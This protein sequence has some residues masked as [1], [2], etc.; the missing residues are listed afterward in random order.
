M[1]Q[2]QQQQ[3]QN[4]NILKHQISSSSSYCWSH[5]TTIIA[6]DLVGT[7]TAVH[8]FQISIQLSSNDNSLKSST[9]SYS[10]TTAD[11]DGSIFEQQQQQQYYY[12]YNDDNFRSYLDNNDDVVVGHNNDNKNNNN[13]INIKRH[14]I[15]S[16]GTT[17]GHLIL[18]EMFLPKMSTNEDYNDNNDDQINLSTNIINNNRTKMTSSATTMANTFRIIYH[19]REMTT[20]PIDMIRFDEFGNRIFIADTS[21]KL[22]VLCNVHEL[23]INA[24]TTTTT[25]T[26]KT[27]TNAIDNIGP[28]LCPTI[29]INLNGIG[30]NQ[31]DVCEKYFTFS[32]NENRIYFFNFNDAN[33]FQVGKS[34]VHM[35][36]P[37]GV[38]IIP[39]INNDY[40]NNGDD[41]DQ[42]S[43]ISDDNYDNDLIY[44]TFI[45]R[46]KCRLWEVNE[47]GQIEFTHQF[48]ELVNRSTTV[49]MDNNNTNN[50]PIFN[51]NTGI[52]ENH[53]NFQHS[54]KQLNYEKVHS[55]G[56][57]YLMYHPVSCDY[58]LVTYATTQQRRRLTTTIESKNV[59][60][61]RIYVIDIHDQSLVAISE[62][63]DGR[64]DV[65]KCLQ[66]EIYVSYYLTND[67]TTNRLRMFVM[68]LNFK[69]SN[70][71][72]SKSSSLLSMD[73]VV[74]QHPTIVS[75]GFSSDPN[76][77]EQETPVEEEEIEIIPVISKNKSLLNL[78]NQLLQK[79]SRL[80]LTSTLHN[81]EEEFE[82]YNCSQCDLPV[83]N[84]FRCI[85]QNQSDQL[86]FETIYSNIETD[87]YEEL[88]SIAKSRRNWPM[89]LRL[90]LA[91]PRLDDRFLFMAILTDDPCLI[92]E[93]SRIK[94]I[95]ESIQWENCLKNLHCQ[96]ISS[97]TESYDRM[98][99]QSDHRCRLCLLRMENNRKK[100]I[101]F[102]EKTFLLSS[103][104]HCHSDIIINELI[105]KTL[106]ILD[107]NPENSYAFSIDFYIRI[108]CYKIMDAAIVDH[109]RLL[110][111]KF[112]QRI[113]RNDNHQ[114][115]GNIEK[116]F[117]DWND[118]QSTY[119]EM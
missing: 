35:N 53:E 76:S 57:L 43:T 51:D 84:F 101:E 8:F 2:H 40:N 59:D 102:F 39:V 56:R 34:T 67:L 113:K 89:Y 103:L 86:L 79:T 32:S 116:N 46:P 10:S 13:I 48:M 11:N 95:N 68:T 108:L 18:V 41:D 72:S 45:S 30:I 23:V 65:L 38:C 91:S 36:R 27:T 80:K 94:P 75:S 44:K 78:Y 69:K 42:S 118:V 90:L 1:K 21:G 73:I 12:Y 110:I 100:L 97:T 29:L 114:I 58:Y 106:T 20:E 112:S 37:P 6:N 77:V 47:I 82:T 62:Q 98:I 31:F 63:F 9:G 93:Q 74:D 26:T 119:N 15:L 88:I 87:Q 49:L 115:S 28:H 104:F 7:V 3:Q 55:F 25:T 81:E 19:C 60:K 16:L 50:T 4:N 24:I 85:D 66:N 117:E 54:S 64:I 52:F 70:D 83:A 14:L 96:L 22:F 107:L 5:Y 17:K 61:S 105:V 92:I 33:C 109:T 99:E 111:N 71:S